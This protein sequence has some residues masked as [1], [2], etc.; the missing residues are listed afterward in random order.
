M[1]RSKLEDA[2]T[3]AQKVHR[4]LEAALERERSLLQERVTLTASLEQQRSELARTKVLLEEANQKDQNAIAAAA[5]EELA[6]SDDR[7]K[8]QPESTP[9]L[10]DGITEPG[11]GIFDYIGI[12]CKVRWL[13]NSSIL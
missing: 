5:V 4:E 9:R 10:D 6:G 11:I 3:Q 8:K 12:D 1:Q 2:D 7:E 13:K